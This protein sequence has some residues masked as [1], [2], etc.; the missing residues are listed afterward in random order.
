QM[1]DEP[2]NDFDD[3]LAYIVRRTSVG[4]T[5]TLQILRDGEEQTVE[6]TL[7]ARPATP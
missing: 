3:L 1:N 5:V 2:I 6:M 4:Q 7:Q